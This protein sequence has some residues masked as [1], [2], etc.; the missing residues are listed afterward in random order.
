MRNIGLNSF[1]K[2]KKNT[3]IFFILTLIMQIM[4]AFYKVLVIFFM[5]IL[6][7]QG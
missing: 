3:N 5:P 1:L 4:L 7:L 2:T 6:N